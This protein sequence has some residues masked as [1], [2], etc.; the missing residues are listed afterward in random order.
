MK[1]AKIFFF[2]IA[3]LFATAHL[4][5]AATNKAPDTLFA[6]P[7]VLQL[8]LEIAPT[9]L[10][11]L[12][13][14]P[15]AYVKAT[16]AEGAT[17]YS[18]IGVRLKGSSSV[19]LL[20]KKPSFTL[21]FNEFESGQRFY[22]NEKVCLNNSASDPSCLSEAIGGE[23]FRAAGVPA[24]K[25]TF[26]QVTLN[27]RDLGLYV[28][29]Q[30]PNRDFLSD[31]FKRAKG[32]YYEGDAADITE[33][34][35]LDSG[36]GPKDNAD[37][38]ALANAAKE[39]DLTQ[40]LNKLRNVLDVDKF[41]NFLAAEVFTANHRGYAINRDNYYVYHDPESDR[42]VFIP[43][44][45]DGLFEKPTTPLMPEFK[46]LLARAV[47]EIPES[48]RLYRERMTQFLSGPFKADT[49]QKRVDDL[50]AKIRPAATRNPEEA[51]IFEAAVT[52]L[53]DAVALRANF[54]GEE[55]K[56]PAM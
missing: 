15:K 49:L 6:T 51:R 12:R 44:G 48:Q 11:D 7:K 38:K 54:I 40:R 41:I 27:G 8:K 18:T 36:N 33:K 13:K 14:S 29:A 9:L 1:D 28:L 19:K 52:Q 5:Q 4:T 26:A 50:A 3:A 56:K 10:E 46:G 16:F 42:I 45:L 21:K 35:R 20:D 25:V 17:N 30:A 39:A 47:L 22:G 34:L 24:A 37:L 23:I 2:A 32:N 53:R 55:L 31:Y 43:D